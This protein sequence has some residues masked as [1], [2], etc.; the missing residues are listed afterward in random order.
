MVDEI[1]RERALN[2]YGLPL[3]LHVPIA[4]VDEE[5]IATYVGDIV[6]PLSRQQDRRALLVE[7]RE[8]LAIDPCYSICEEP[9][10]AIFHTRRQVWV[11][12]AY[13]SYRSA[14]RRAFPDADITG[15]VLSHAMNR[16][17]AALKGFNFIRLTPASRRANSSSAFSE[18]WG[19]ALHSGLGQKAAGRQLGPFIQYADLTELMLMLDMN[20]GGGVMDLVN[21]G[22]KLIRPRAADL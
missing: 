11:H 22:Q 7:T 13:N 20:L 18:Q 12:Y 10:S 15:L 2:R 17:V 1:A 9:G 5:A 3:C 21:E 19:V 6:R 8:Q 16:R 14:Y 4:A